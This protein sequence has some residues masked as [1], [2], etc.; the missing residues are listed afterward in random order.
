MSPKSRQLTDPVG[1][2]VRYVREQL[3]GQNRSHA[4]GGSCSALVLVEQG[5][6][7]RQGGGRRRR[8]K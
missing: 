7:D 1:R 6:Q 8:P 4:S 5:R 3:N 2:I